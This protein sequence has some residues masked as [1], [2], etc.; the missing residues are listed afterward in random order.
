MFIKNAWYVGALESEVGREPMGRVILNEPIVFFR[1]EDGTP[2]ALEDRCCHR[3]YPLSHGELHGDRLQCS[4]HGMVYDA[5]GACVE[6]PSQKQVPKGAGVRNYPV[7]ERYHWVWIW[8]GDPELANPD[9]ITDFHW[10][11]DPNWGAK[12]TLIHIESNYKLIVENLLD[13]TH[14]AYVHR[15]TIGND[16]VAEAADTKFDREPGSVRVTRWI[17][18]QPPP[19]A[20]VKSGGFTGNVD[21]WQIIDYSPPAFVRLDIGACDTGTGAPE[22]N[23]VGGI[24]MRNLNA[25]TPETERSTHYFWGQAHSFDVKNE[26]IT[27]LVFDTVMTAFLEDKAIFEAQQRIIDMNPDANRI[28]LAGDVGG[29]AATDIISRKIAEEAA[30]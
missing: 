27:N 8:M 7:V 23:R 16:A 14:L 17:I 9:E 5:T 15:T 29:V 24:E 13:L 26:N 11:D 21:R 1:K 19:P 30:A 22:G 6:I 3:H 20:F 28:N 12:S 25:I 10:L 18:D 2:V 4:Y